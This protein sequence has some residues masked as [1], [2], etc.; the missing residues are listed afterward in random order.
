MVQIEIVESLFQEIERRFKGE[1]AEIFDLMESLKENS[2]KGKELGTVGGI[3]IKE[4]RCNGFRFYFLADGFKLKLL[5]ESDL[6]DLFLRFVRMSDK[7]HQQ[8]VIEEI[9]VILRTIGPVRF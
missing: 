5:G 3:V 7:K 4:L 6:T 2:K 1:A 9:K 8:K